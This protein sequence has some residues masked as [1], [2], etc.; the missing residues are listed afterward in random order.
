MKNIFLSTW[1]IS[2]SLF[3]LLMVRIVTPYLSWEWNVDFLMTKQNIIHLLHYRTAFYLH[4]FSSCFI[5]FAGAFLFSKLVIK[6]FR[7]LHRWAG[8][9]YVLLLLLISAPTGLIMG[10]YA[11]GGWP[12]KISFLILCPLWWYCTYKGYQKIRQKKIKEHEIW[13]IRSYALTLSAI[14]LRFYQMILGSSFIDPSTL[15]IIVSWL[16]WVGNLL[17]AEIIVV[18]KFNLKPFA[19]GKLKMT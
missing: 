5:L 7:Q 1:I 2:I 11:N 17:I 8:K 12:A 6:K 9:I 13:M 10:F 16:S 3:T 19:I 15:Y 4:I 14:S 18:Y